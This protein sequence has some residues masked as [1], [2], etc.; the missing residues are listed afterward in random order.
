MSNPEIRTADDLLTMSYE[1]DSFL[2]V[3][4]CPAHASTDW[5]LVAA[6]E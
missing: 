6:G 4:P 5:K 1:R 3:K 2:L